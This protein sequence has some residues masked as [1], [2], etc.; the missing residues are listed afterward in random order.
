VGFSLVSAWRL[1]VQQHPS[2][3]ALVDLTPGQLVGMSVKG[4]LGGALSTAL[5]IGVAFFAVPMLSRFVVMGRAIGTASMLALP[6]A[7]A[8][9]AGYLFA[10][11]P[12]GCESCT[13]YVHLPAVA[14]VGVASVIGAPLGAQLSSI[15]STARLRQ[16]FAVLLIA[17]AVS[18]LF[19]KLPE[20]S[21]DAQV[22]LS[23]PRL[24]WPDDSQPAAA[25]DWLGQEPAQSA[26]YLASGHGP[27]RSFLPL[28]AGERAPETPDLGASL[29]G[30]MLEPS[31]ATDEPHGV[32]FPERRS[33]AT[34]RRPAAPLRRPDPRVRTV[35]ST[36][37]SAGSR[38]QADDG[39]RP[40]ATTTPPDLLRTLYGR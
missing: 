19:K 5:G 35:P 29:D 23:A 15:L 2:A 3:A 18:L 20:L 33:A 27:R 30:R 21:A 10:P 7:M 34:P 12:E 1:L 9:A 6:M 25:P 4:L 37:S 28:L 22:A 40:A 38:P 26:H 16:I 24:S 11:A 36:A 14:A 13:G 39:A 32:P 17:G 8:G 31:S